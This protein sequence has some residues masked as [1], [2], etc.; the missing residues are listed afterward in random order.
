MK[1]IMFKPLFFI[2]ATV[3][4]LQFGFL[5]AA[6]LTPEEI[7]T[8][9]YNSIQ[10]G[11]YEKAYG[12]ISQKMKDG[13]SCQEWA[14]DW[15]KTID[16]SQFVLFEF[17]VETAKIEGDTATVRSWNKSKDMFNKD[18]IVE[19][20]TD[21]LVKENGIWKLDMTKVDLPDV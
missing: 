13:K 15:K 17:G 7:V 11:D 12:F 1:R 4:M 14:A 3:V 8:G 19:H 10:N 6:D 21:Y 5:Y 2:T 18:G 9:Y 16:F 20:E